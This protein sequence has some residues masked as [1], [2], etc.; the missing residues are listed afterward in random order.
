MVGLG[1]LTKGRSRSSK[2]T[3]DA[4]RCTFGATCQSKKNR[5]ID[6]GGRC[7]PYYSLNL[8]FMTIAKAAF[9]VPTPAR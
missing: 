7:P 1:K 8:S 5:T 2:I 3:P 9:I 4:V 6:Y